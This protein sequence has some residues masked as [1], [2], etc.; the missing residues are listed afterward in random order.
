M[1]IIHLSDLHFHRNDKDNQK[2]LKTLKKVKTKYPDHYLVITGDIVDDGHE[3]Q[4]ENAL[5]AFKPFKDRIFIAPGNHDFG[6]V[7]N[8]YSKGKAKRFDDMLSTPLNQD[9]TFFEENKP[10][11]NVVD[12]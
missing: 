10:V 1:R 8:F 12:D 7:G 2:G 5:N 3:K 9:G 6:A 11:V 4:Y